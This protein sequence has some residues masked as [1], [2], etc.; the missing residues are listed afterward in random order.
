L[1]SGVD[2]LGDHQPLGLSEKIAVFAPIPRATHITLIAVMPG[3]E[4]KER[5]L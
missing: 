4:A 2:E 3:A 5:T 1:A